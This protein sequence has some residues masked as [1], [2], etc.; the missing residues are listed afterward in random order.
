MNENFPSSFAPHSVQ[1]NPQ[2]SQEFAYIDSSGIISGFYS[3]VPG[4]NL[5]RNTGYSLVLRDFYHSLQANARIYQYSDTNV[6][7]FFVQFIKN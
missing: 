6:M 7:Q 5:G 2:F 4:S 1:Q 3:A